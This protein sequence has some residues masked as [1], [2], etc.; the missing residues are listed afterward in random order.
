MARQI[1]QEFLDRHA[2]V[3]RFVEAADRSFWADLADTSEEIRRTTYPGGRARVQEIRTRDAETQVRPPAVD[4]W[5]QTDPP[6]PELPRGR[7]GT[8]SSDDDSIIVVRETPRRQPVRRRNRQPSPPPPETLRE[9]VEQ[10]SCWNCGGRHR[11]SDCRL[12]RTGDLCFGCGERRVTLR[13]CPRCATA[14]R[15]TR[16]YTAPRGPRD[17]RRGPPPHVESEGWPWRRR[18]S[19]SSCTSD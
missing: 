5:S 14:Y 8:P 10:I 1:W 2:I 16:P 4:E 15:R 9:L 17:G 13:N 19:R 11:Y 12:P 6:A 7:A 18:G 3:W